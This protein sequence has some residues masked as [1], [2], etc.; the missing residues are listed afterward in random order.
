MLDYSATNR[1]SVRKLDS[2]ILL[3]CLDDY[4][5]LTRDEVGRGL[6]HGDGL[7]RYFDKS[8]QFVV[9]ENG[10]AGLN[11]EHSMMDATPTYRLCDYVCS[12]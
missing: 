6:W 7:N 11:G 2:A 8:L 10:K 1:E 5:P 12:R 4:S 9:F 3:M